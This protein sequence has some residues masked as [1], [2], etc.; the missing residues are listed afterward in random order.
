MTGAQR[1]WQYRYGDPRKDKRTEAEKEADAEDAFSELPYEDRRRWCEALVR[2]DDHYNPCGTLGMD[3]FHEVRHTEL[4]FGFDRER[5]QKKDRLDINVCL[6]PRYPSHRRRDRMDRL[7]TWRRYNDSAKV[8]D[9][10]SGKNVRAVFHLPRRKMLTV[11][12]RS[13]RLQ[14]S[15]DFRF[16]FTTP[17]GAKY[18]GREVRR[19]WSQESRA[20]RLRARRYRKMLR[21]QARLQAQGMPGRASGHTP[22]A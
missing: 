22:P 3:Y 17:T 6:P 1:H 4:A 11:F 12:L 9:I 21:R 14:K 8:K 10:P 2:W 13:R 16:R 5:W 18:S 19:E 20:L 7:I 15:V